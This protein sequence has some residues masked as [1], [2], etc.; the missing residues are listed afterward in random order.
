MPNTHSNRNPAQLQSPLKQRL[1]EQKE[2][3]KPEELLCSLIFDEM[4]IKPVLKYVEHTD[5][6]IG[7]VT[8]GKCLRLAYRRVQQFQLAHRL[9]CFMLKGLSTSYRISVAY[10]FTRQLEGEEPADL[11]Q[12]KVLEKLYDWLGTIAM[13]M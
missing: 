11:L 9:L 4:A 6:Y 12:T 7:Q 10:F 3:L 1:T 8:Y 13:S 2:H 5:R